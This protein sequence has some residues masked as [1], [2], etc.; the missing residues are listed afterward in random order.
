MAGTIQY[1]NADTSVPGHAWGRLRDG[2][3]PELVT[4]TSA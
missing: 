1:A 3:R 2:E 4:G